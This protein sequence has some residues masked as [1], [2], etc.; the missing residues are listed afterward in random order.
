MMQGPSPDLR[1]RIE[2]E[3]KG[4]RVPSRQQHRARST[5]V[6]LASVMPIVAMAAMRGVHAGGRPLGYVATIAI[7]WTALA[8]LATA[9]VLRSET[10]LGRPRPALAALAPALPIALATVSIAANLAFPETLHGMEDVAPTG[11]MCTAMAIGLSV[12]PVAALLYVYRRSDPVRPVALGGA[13]G[14]VAASWSGAV[15]ATQCPQ[16]TPGHVVLAHVVP[17]ALTAVVAAVVGSR[18]LALRW[19]R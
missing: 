5:A 14:A 15:L 12:L 8:A 10:T 17:I 13:L 19:I 1:E 16:T 7:A 4:R 2:A 3:L 9:F 18:V 11:L 6:I